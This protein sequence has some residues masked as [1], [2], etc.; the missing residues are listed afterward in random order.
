MLLFKVFLFFLIHVYEQEKKKKKKD[1]ERTV[2]CAVK[3]LSDM[4]VC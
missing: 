1:L 4:R 3:L 2:I